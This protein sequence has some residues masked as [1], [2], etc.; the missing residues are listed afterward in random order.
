MTTKSLPLNIFNIHLLFDCY[1]FY[2]VE[3][4]LAAH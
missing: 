2:M 4:S 1:L 3:L